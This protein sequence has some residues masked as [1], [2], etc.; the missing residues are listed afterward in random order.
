MLQQA[1]AVEREARAV[2][3]EARALEREAGGLVPPLYPPYSPVSPVLP[4]STPIPAQPTLSDLQAVAD[5][6]TAMSQRM[7][8]QP[9]PGPELRLV[10]RI[11]KRSVETS[12]E[13][14]EGTP[15]GDEPVDKA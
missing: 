7:L 8:G 2:E 13:I 15:V 11:H 12:K 6:M 9:W 14:R 1:L 3:R 10:T 5:R 4:V